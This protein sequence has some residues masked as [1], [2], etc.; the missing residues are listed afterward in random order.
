MILLLSLLV[1][2][3][4][5][6]YEATVVRVVDGDTVNV[7]VAIWPDLTVAASIR[8]LGL[9]TPELKGKCDSERTLAQKAKEMSAS[10]MP[11]GS[12]ITITRISADKFGGRYDADVMLASGEMLNDKLIGA[13]LARA[14]AGGKR[15]GWCGP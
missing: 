11:V 10:L 13:G 6:G 15:A 14:Y 1:A 5:N 7:T 2:I 4:I 3:F 8:I 12:Q 9:D